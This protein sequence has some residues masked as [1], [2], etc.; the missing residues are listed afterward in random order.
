MKK[1][2]LLVAVCILMLPF[3]SYADEALYK[4]KCVTCHGTDGKK[5]AKFDLTSD[6]VQGLSD[7]DIVKFL[8]TNTIHKS[9]VNPADAKSIVKY[10]RTLKK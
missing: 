10:L 8:T 1:V 9:K 7:D 4:A 6:K 3:A 2:A 5:N